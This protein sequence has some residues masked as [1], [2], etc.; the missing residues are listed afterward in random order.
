MKITLIRTDRESGKETLT[1]YE[2]NVLIERIKKETKTKD[3]TGLRTMLRYSSP[4]NRAEYIH[5]DKIPRVYPS[6]EYGKTR[7]GE[8]RMR[9][10]NGVVMLE[11]NKLAGPSEAEL[12]KSQAKLLPQTWAAFTGSSGQS[13]KI[14][15]KF[16]LPDGS[17]P[18]KEEEITAFHAH[19]YRMAVQCYQPMLT[20]P[21]TLKQ[22]SPT[23]SCRMT[24]DPAP[25][26]N[27]EAMPFCL[28][29][30]LGMPGEQTFRQHQL[31]EENPL[32]RMN[33]GYE[34]SHTFTLLFETALDKAFNEM[35]NWKRDDDL[36]PLLVCLADHCF[37][38]GIP[39]EETIRQILIHYYRQAD[40][41]TV[42]TTIHNLYRES[43]GFGKKSPL[44]PEQE[45]S[46]RLE[47]FM[48]RRYEFRFNTVI[49]NLEY[50]QR[51]S[52]HFYFKP[53]D[54]RVQSSIALD[55][56]QEGI[57]AWDR[58]IKR[59]L[60]S[61]RIPLY[62]PIEEYLYNVGQW[63]G[64][65]RIQALANLVPCN[66]PHWQELF[67]RW[68]LNMVAHW[69]GLDK[70]HS[71]STSPLL[72]GAQG[73][74]KSTFCRLLLPPE[75]RF[76][77]TDSLDFKS[78][79]DAEM[80]LGRFLLINLDEF[81]QINVNQQG[82]L[83]HLLQKPVANLRKP[84]GSSIQEMRRYASFIGT[85]NQKDLLTDP[86]GSRRFICV[87]VTAPINT[88]VTINYR[89]LYAEALRA[90]SKGERYW[91][92]DADEAILRES[93]KEFEQ[94]SSVEQLFHCYFHSPEKGE[95]GEYLSPMQILEYLHTKAREIKLTGSSANTF[96]RTLRKLELEHKKT[97]KGVVYRVVRM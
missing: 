31:A 86:S 50:R 40:E 82:F 36:Q 57:Q 29:Q 53:V 19:A 14:W 93:N 76:G 64:K 33:P 65:Q 71:N 67:Y 91:F 2:P 49:N 81:D 73:Y 25:Y 79:R 83:K 94:M 37:K 20:F 11:V 9:R 4:E 88:N 95:E 45:T 87:E 32:L 12:L 27:P 85:S 35:E 38:A 97:N 44:V 78:K 55:A 28:E 58:D 68:F 56:L 66:N 24:L 23:R 54:Q 90:I 34:T 80:Y 15:V 60:S 89:Q 30:P 18:A 47:E 92:D 26:Y 13:L 69:R 75:L 10:Y 5:I 42:R 59:Y 61:N 22:P 72:I 3:I 63:D 17:L 39:E 46:L 48:E 41:Q 62:N 70:L 43:K 21:I 16:A 52:I 51:D 77:Y 7:E 1:N 8:K 84:Y 6:V 96:G 74:R